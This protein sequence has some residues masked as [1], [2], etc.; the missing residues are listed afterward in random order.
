MRKYLLLIFLF[1]LLASPRPAAQEFTEGLFTYRVLNDD[2][3]NPTTNV[4]IV[5]STVE[6][7]ADVV[8]PETTTFDGQEY[9]VRQ[10][11]ALFPNGEGA[12]RSLYLPASIYSIGTSWFSDEV[13]VNEEIVISEEN[14]LYKAV[15]NVVYSKD[16]TIL[17]GA[18]RNI[19][20]AI[21]LNGVKRIADAAYYGC[22]NITEVVLPETVESIGSQAFS[23]CPN[24]K[25][26]IL[27][28]GL[29]S[30]DNC[31]SGSCSIKSVTIPSTVE[32]L[33]NFPFCC[34]T[35]EEFK[36]EEYNSHYKSL[37]GCIYS[38][39]YAKL[40]AVPCAK[41]SISYPV[42]LKVIGNKAF[43]KN[44]MD[45][46]ILPDRITELEEFAFCDASASRIEVPQTVTKLSFGLFTGCRLLKNFNIPQSIK[47]IDLNVFWDCK[48]L[49][50]ITSVS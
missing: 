18:T 25:T 50:N 24:L 8:I 34:S 43:Q 31:F 15:D 14:Q 21:I 11:Q 28:K 41:R 17:F 6:D 2:Q 30:L 36:V 19:E 45:E 33:L 46:I 1:G 42:T 9:T 7:N 44:I 20:K 26:V 12:A 10:L 3:G 32:L 4:A 5:S 47:E 40:C 23:D 35:L 37:S 16:G 22:A 39:D 49:E 48:S 29:K 13:R 27:N 38:S